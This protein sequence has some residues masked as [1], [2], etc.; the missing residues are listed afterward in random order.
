MK[1]KVIF[2]VVSLTGSFIIF[3]AYNSVNLGL[4]DHGNVSCRLNYDLIENSLLIFPLIL[5]F[6]TLTFF[7]PQAIFRSWLKYT[8][9][10][11]PVIIAIV[12]IINLGW[13]HTHGGWFNTSDL[14]DWPAQILLY[15]LYCL[16]S[17]AVIGRG[18]WQY[19]QR[20]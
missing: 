3:L 4:C 6:S 12:F 16:G 15:S 14:F 18:Y 2:F 8:L 17:V 7:L 11:A 9:I 10:V 1:N 20:G 5:L 19:R 13:H